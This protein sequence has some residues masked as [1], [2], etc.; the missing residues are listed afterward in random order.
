MDDDDKDSGLVF[1]IPDLWGPSR[2]LGNVDG[3]PSFLF[4]ELKL[5]GW[6]AVV[7]ERQQ[8]LIFA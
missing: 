5:D 7:C 2:W 3:V 8:L 4:S 6:F 1:V